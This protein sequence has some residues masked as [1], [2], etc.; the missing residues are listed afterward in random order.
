MVLDND[1]IK[2]LIENPFNQ[3]IKDWQKEH[4][5]LD[6]YYNGGDVSSE[7]EKVK[8]Y[9]NNEQKKLRDKIARSTKDFLSNLL[10]PLNKVF[11]AS[12]FN[13][14]IEI[15]SE[16]ALKNFTN[17]LEELPEGISM[18][19]WMENYWKE[20]LVTDPNGI[21]F[22]EVEDKEE[23][24]KAYPTYKSIL[25][26]HDYKVK[27]GVFEYVIFDYGKRKLNNSEVHVYRVFDEIKD[28]LYYI[29]NNELKEYLEAGKE[30]SIIEHKYGFIPAVLC[31]DIVDK[32]TNG[33]KSFINKIDE[34]LKEYM[35]DSSVHS[36]YKFLHGF[37][38]FWR[39]AAKCT[40]C[41]GTGKIVKESST[42]TPKEKVPCPTCSGK[43]QKITS[44]VSDGVSLPIPNK[45]QPKLAPD[46]AGYV[47]PDLDTWQK[48]LDEMKEMKSDMH[49]ALWGTYTND[50]VKAETATAR[51]IDEQPVQ[52]TLKSVS[53]TAESIES[54]LIEFQGKIMYGEMFKS[55]NI[56]YGKRFLIETPDV[57]WNRYLNAK[58]DQAP[59]T[60]LDYLY[61]QFIMAEYHNDKSMMDAKLNEFYIEPFPHYSLSDLANIATPKQ[62]QQKLLFSEWNSLDTTDYSKPYEVLKKSFEEY[63][64]SNVDSSINTKN[65]EKIT[66]GQGDS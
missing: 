43:G 49:F 20:A 9:E 31:S 29:K 36:I 47:Q 52:E 26:I 27:W 46:I 45:D 44:D 38:I 57:L 14:E 7:L 24:P 39:Y 16:E 25:T 1:Q 53:T 22:V 19:K 55:A 34:V 50:D 28:G 30:T 18:T 40:T 33:R 2:T 35:R 63:F 65:N 8:N 3:S 12:G 6:I 51:F 37:P 32:K 41:L 10:N 11:T 13:S 54:R 17:H 21:C 66:T 61:K 15:S 59:I 56:K 4:K 23:D 5:V 48:Q 60:T 58:K 62:I 64:S 42:T